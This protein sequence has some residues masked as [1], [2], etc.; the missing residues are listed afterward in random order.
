MK[1][2][3]LDGNN[4]QDEFLTIHRYKESAFLKVLNHHPETELVLII[5]ST[6]TQFV[7]D[8]IEKFY[9]GDLILIGSN[10]PH[11]L[12]NDEEYFQNIPSLFA[13]AIVIHF[14]KHQYEKEILSLP[15]MKMIRHLLERSQ[16]GI[17]FF[18]KTKNEVEHRLHRMMELNDFDKILESI[19]ILQLL[20]TSGEFVYLSSEGYQQSLAH[21]KANGDI[22]LNK[23]YEFLAQN[24]QQDISLQTIAS[25]TSMNPSSFCRYF[26]KIHSK[27]LSD[28]IND[29]RVGHACKLLQENAKSV[30]QICFESGFGSL[31]N[32]N[33]QFKKRKDISPKA[34]AKKYDLLIKNQEAL[35]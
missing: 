23:V 8:S 4:N 33:R 29:I 18:G 12:M 20:A 11:L 5:R 22:R 32:F 27:T 7:G 17:K 26:K 34:Y 9:P 31:S 13:D 24:F 28:Y 14:H 1:P 35:P 15:E 30:C 19:E 25:L 10:L 2:K 21:N 3:Y 6:G 16:R